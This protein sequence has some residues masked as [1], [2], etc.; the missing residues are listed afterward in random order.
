MAS[1]KIGAGDG[2]IFLAAAF[3]GLVVALLGG[4]EDR[5]RTLERGCRL[6]AILRSDFIFGKEFL[7][8]IVVELL[9]LQIG[10]GIDHRLL[11]RLHFLL[12]GAGQRERKIRFAHA[13]RRLRRCAP[14]A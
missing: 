14:A 4:L 7:R 13:H 12:A 1:V 2:D 3:H 9:L 10:L 5:L 11:R 6:V 8:A